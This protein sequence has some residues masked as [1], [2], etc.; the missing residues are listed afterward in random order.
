MSTQAISRYRSTENT[1]QLM[2]AWSLLYSP[3]PVTVPC[4]IND[5]IY[6]QKK[7]LALVSTP[8]SLEHIFTGQPSISSTLC[9]VCSQRTFSSTTSHPFHDCSSSMTKVLSLTVSM[10]PIPD[11]PPF[12]ALSTT[13]CTRGIP[14]GYPFFNCS[15][16]KTCFLS[17]VVQL[18][19]TSVKQLPNLPIH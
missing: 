17:R 14:D 16:E 7:S 18:F 3:P 6:S 11:L 13:N 8:E 15:L 4:V 10:D 5:D 2:F 1:V 19:M 9:N 12:S